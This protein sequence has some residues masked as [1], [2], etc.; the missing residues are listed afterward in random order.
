MTA[1]GYSDFLKK[2][3]N[4]CSLAERCTQDVMQKLT[5][6][7]VPEEE[8]DSIIEALRHEKFLDDVRYA[9]SFVSDKWKLDLW[10]RSKIKNGLFQKGIAEVLI[11][12]AL[13]TI[14]QDAYLSG[15]EAL[16]V[17]K[18]NT[19]S[20]EAPKQQMKKLIAF[21][22]SRGFEEELIWQ[23]LEREGLSF[24]TNDL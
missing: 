9:N 13:D 4:Y 24:D 2:G 15:M 11:Q 5:A 20:S 18:R 16:L 12:N 22:N 6:W 23:W 1:S 7:G 19:I 10:G 14:D 3:M 21:G 8:V 17:K